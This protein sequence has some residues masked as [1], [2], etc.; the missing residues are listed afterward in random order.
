MANIFQDI[1]LKGIRAGQMPERTEESRTW[2]KDKASRIDRTRVKE[3]RLFKESSSS[4]PLVS[5]LMP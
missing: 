2:Y 5:V 4:S 3:E 1:L